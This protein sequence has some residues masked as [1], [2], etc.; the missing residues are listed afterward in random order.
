[1]QT[2]FRRGGGKISRSK[3]KSL[4][5]EEEQSELDS[6]LVLLDREDGLEMS[7][8]APDCTGRRWITLLPP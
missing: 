2:T 1:M 6:L 3:S 7:C 5:Q 4:I 8:V